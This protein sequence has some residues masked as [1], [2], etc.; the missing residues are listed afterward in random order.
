MNCIFCGRTFR[1][2]E[3]RFY[4]FGNGING[5]S[6]RECW[7]VRF[8]RCSQCGDSHWR[9]NL[10]T[11]H[12]NTILCHRCYRHYSPIGNY[13][14]NP[15]PEFHRLEYENT[16]YF[17]I[18]LE[19]ETMKANLRELAV[20]FKKFLSQL[21][22]NNKLFIKSD[23]SL[24]N[25]FEI[26]TQPTTLQFA[27]K[28]LYLYEILQWLRFNGFFSYE[29]GRCGLHIHFSLFDLKPS[30]K[31][32]LRIF[33]NKCQ[34]HLKRFSKRKSFS[35]CQFTDLLD[36]NGVEDVKEFAQ[37]G[38]YHA[39]N[40]NTQKSTYEMRVFRGT[41]DHPRFLASLQFTDAMIEFCKVAGESFLW[42]S[43]EEMIWDEFMRFTKEQN[44]YHHFVKYTKK[45][46]LERG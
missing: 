27:H 46:N 32:K 18:E 44:R 26:C 42:V 16:R 1:Y 30:H 43:P 9:E 34:S 39:L 12:D 5:E 11:T 23:G 29:E 13:H 14:S 22:I 17:G 37:D 33:V 45:H 7:E 20:E 2:A 4:V 28:S 40:I 25:G 35:Y 3:R 19:V 36:T 21:G 6:C 10:R 31:R 41:L 15:E 38:R 8:G 24:N